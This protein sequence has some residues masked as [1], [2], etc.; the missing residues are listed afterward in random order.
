MLSDNLP[1]VLEIATD[2]MSFGVKVSGK[3]IE[4]GKGKESG[5]FTARLI[6][7]GKPFSLFSVYT[8]G[9][10][11]VNIGWNYRK[12][13]ELNPNLSENYRN[14]AA[15]ELAVDFERKSWENGWPTAQ[16][17]SLLLDN[18]KTFKKIITDFVAEV[19]GLVGES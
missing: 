11:S 5:S 18:A 6:V 15:K 10:F 17:S 2:L 12:L 3:Q 4:W 13:E 7:K 14:R 19:K 1:D 16:L 9:K 8:Y